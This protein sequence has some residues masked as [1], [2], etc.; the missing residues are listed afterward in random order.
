M[1]DNRSLSDYCRDVALADLQ[2]ISERL[3]EI[4]LYVPLS[5]LYAQG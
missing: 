2:G 4:A 3:S 5:A 1:K